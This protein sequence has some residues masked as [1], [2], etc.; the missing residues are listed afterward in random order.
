VLSESFESVAAN[1]HPDLASNPLQ[2][3]HVFDRQSKADPSPGGQQK[4]AL[5]G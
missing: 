4:T 2:R 1:G 3:V 5:P